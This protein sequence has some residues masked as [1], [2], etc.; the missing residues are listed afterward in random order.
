MRMCGDLKQTAT[1]CGFS[2]VFRCS[3]LDPAPSRAPAF[4]E[5]VIRDEEADE[6]KGVM[7]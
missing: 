3:G 1:F 7:S 4:T 2:G 5:A 6:K